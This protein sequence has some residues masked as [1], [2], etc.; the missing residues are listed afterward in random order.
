MGD[1]PGSRRR[2]GNMSVKVFIHGLDVDTMKSSTPP[3]VASTTRQ[4]IAFLFSL[5]K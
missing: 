3:G 2:D 4:G 1:F 5:K